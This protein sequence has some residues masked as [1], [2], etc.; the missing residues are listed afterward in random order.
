MTASPATLTESQFVLLMDDDQMITD[1]L[2]AALE[3]DGRTIITC[4]D[5]ESAQIAVER[6]RPSHVVA[7]IHISG[8]FSYEGLDFIRYAKRYAPEAKIILISGDAPDAVQLEGA[9]RGAVA[10]LQKPF[11]VS[12]LDA[13][14]DLMAA[15]AS[16]S[17]AHPARRIRMPP[18]DEILMSSELNP[19]F[20]PIVSLRESWRHIGYEALAR[21]RC[22]SPFRNPEV[23][24]R[25]AERKQRIADLEFACA[26][27]SFRTAAALP[28]SGQLFLNIHPEVFT[29]GE[30]LCE[31]IARESSNASFPLDRLVLEITEQSQLR[32]SPAVLQTFARLQEMGVRFAFD[33]LGI[34][35]SHLPLIDRIRPSYLKVSQHFG[36]GFEADPTKRKVIANLLSLAHDFKCELILEGIESESTAHAAAHL[37]ITLGQGFF[38]GLPADASTFRRPTAG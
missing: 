26:A 1:G 4:N 16:S 6:L 12:E 35:Y 8:P 5:V 28:G 18:I 2:A 14:L 30:R 20:Q 11:D 38:F 22:D 9:E 37:G 24:F 19:F 36:T 15:A 32:E 3:R 17:S 34:A 33:D 13:M 31:T 23:L 27:R 29:E 25:Y 10:F 7:D 21:F